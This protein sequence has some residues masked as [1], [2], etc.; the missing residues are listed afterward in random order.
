V[1]R[2]DSPT[3]VEL[4]A[5]AKVNLGLRVLG[6]RPD[7][8]HLLESLFVPLELADEVS[9][10]VLAE[11]HS[12]APSVAFSLAFGEGLGAAGDIPDGDENLAVRAGRAFLEAA[13]LGG[14]SLG[15]RVEKR[16]PAAAGLG[17]GSSDAG[18][19][20][21]ALAQL[22]PGALPGGELARLALELGADVPF[23]LDPRPALVSGVGETIE[24]V[25]GVP[26]LVLLLANPGESLATAEVYSALDVLR[27]SLTTVGAGSTM[28]ALSGLQSD[29]NAFA[30]LLETLLENDL[31]PPAVRLCPAIAR[32]REQIRV[33]GALVVGMSGSG[34]TVFGV[35]PNEADAER[36]LARAR[37]EVATWAQIV[38]SV[39]SR[40][41]HSDRA[42]LQKTR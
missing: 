22:F 6:R 10:E 8:Y 19:V 24:P 25:E 20:L 38:R 7:G 18:A 15:I 29:P 16:I 3:R 21:R 35:F 42:E 40:Q 26:E 33:A 14:V 1:V 4:L 2:F 39:G 5:P 12:A 9:V 31:E 11:V 23:F 37:F 30:N 32:L 27:P 28:R 34:A 13:R 36:A 17:G 41:A